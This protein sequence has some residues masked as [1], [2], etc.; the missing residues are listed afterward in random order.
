MVDFTRR[1]AVSVLADLAL[2]L[3]VAIFVEATANF[4]ASRK[5]VEFWLGGRRFWVSA[6]ADLAQLLVTFSVEVASDFLVAARGEWLILAGRAAVLALADLALLLVP[7]SVEVAG[8]RL[9]GRPFR[10][11]CWCLFRWRR[12]FDG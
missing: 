3:I 7:V 9:V 4:S 5:S 6:L 12:I 8:F 10:R 1:A 11:C 2:L